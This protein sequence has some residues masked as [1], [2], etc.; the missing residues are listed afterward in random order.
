MFI[1]PMLLDTIPEPFDDDNY[2]TELKFD[3]F[4][5]ILSKHNGKIRLYTRHKNEITAK[6]PE[7]HDL[8]I[9]DNTILDG[10]I[11]VMQ[12][13][14]VD[15][16]AV[17]ERFQSSK[18]EH[19][20][21]FCVFDV[22]KVNDLN[23][24]FKP[25]HERKAE[26]LKL[27]LQHPN[28]YVLEGMYGDAVA[29]FEIAKQNNLEGIVMKRADSYYHINKRSA[30]WKKV[31]NYAY[32]DVLITGHKAKES[33]FFLAYPDGSSAGAMEFMPINQRRKFHQIKEVINQ[34]DDY[35]K[36]KPLPLTV[37]HRFLTKSGKLRIPSFHSW[38]D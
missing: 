27:N 1:S 30:D 20:I 3:G 35:V 11:V 29:Y 26:L 28:V 34:S 36:I 24:T 8:D 38:G 15:F 31:I 9:P 16:E 22:V 25:L 13:G 33:L 23:L 21:T 37:K 6:F 2:I 12:D 14:T 32:S 10:E 4:R 19:S 5:C 17:M 7:L 18:S